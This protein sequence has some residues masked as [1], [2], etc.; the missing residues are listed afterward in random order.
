MN[1]AIRHDTNE[2]R[3]RRDVSPLDADVLFDALIAETDE[4]LLTGLL[5]AWAAKGATEDEIYR[6]AAILRGRM[7]RV[8][9]RG[10]ACVDIVGTGGS[11]EKTFNVSTAAAFVVVRHAPAL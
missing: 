1:V 7:K 11:N 6:F 3:S 5:Q 4:E 9:T 2:F 8:D 10:L